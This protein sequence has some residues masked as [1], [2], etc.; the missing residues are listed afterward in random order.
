MNTRVLSATVLMASALYTAPAFSGAIYANDV[1]GTWTA[2][3]PEAPAVTGLG[4]STILW[5]NPTYYGQK[6]GYRFEGFA[7]PSYEVEENSLFEQGRFIHFNYPITGSTL[8]TASLRVG[9][10]L[11]ID[12]LEKTVESVFDFTH[13]ETVNNPRNGICANG[14]YNGHGVNY[15]GCADRV[16]FSRN[17]GASEEVVIGNKAYYVD[18]SGFFYNHK[19]ADEFWT[20]EYWKNKATLIGSIKSR[21]IEVPEPGTL[22]LF[23]LGLLGMGLSRRKA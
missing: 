5:G 14:S 18:I 7:P 20:V 1:S 12:G 9:T 11:S 17:E 19:L 4:T 13:W 10:T 21:A 16:T 6:S 23:G 15:Y 2:T 8:E 3:T 22:A